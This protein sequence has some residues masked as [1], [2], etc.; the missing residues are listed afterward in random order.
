VTTTAPSTNLAGFGD[1]GGIFGTDIVTQR[2]DETNIDT[3]RW[4]FAGRVTHFLTRNTS[5][6]L[7]FTYNQQTS[8]S[9]SLGDP[10]DFD[11]YLVTLGVTHVFQPIKLW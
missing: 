4:G 5:G 8:K 11:D 2:S 10:S 1:P 6:Y 7:Q 3:M 9:D